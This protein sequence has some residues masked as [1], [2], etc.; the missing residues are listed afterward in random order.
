[1]AIGRHG[2]GQRRGAA[3]GA[4]LLALGAALVAALAWFALR[5]P[6]ADGSGPPAGREDPARR[7][8]QGAELEAPAAD[9][10]PLAELPAGAD[11]ARSAG[12][13][14]P[15]AGP[16]FD[17][18][19]LDAATGERVARFWV[20]RDAFAEVAA[21]VERFQADPETGLATLGRSAPPSP[22]SVRAPGYVQAQAMEPAPPGA[23]VEVRLTRESSIA[24]I[25][26]DGA[27]A[28][29]PAA[30]VWLEWYGPD[31]DALAGDGDPL[32]YE[33]ARFVRTDREGAY[34][35]NG[36]TPGVYATRA[37]VGGVTVRSDRAW[38]DEGE[39]AE[40]DHWLEQHA[41]V[42]ARV[43]AP[44]GTPAPKSLVLLTR[45][46]EDAGAQPA[47]RGYTGDDGRVTL[48]PLGAGRYRVVVVSDAGRS[49]VG[50]VTVPD[51]GSSE[52]DHEVRL[53]D[54]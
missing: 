28:P 36:L 33:G 11:A 12:R 40:I 51:R 47:A 50:F 29:V 39:W 35:F 46:E 54:S 22:L 45:A 6:G 21:G 9:P 38:V 27:S 24:G 44:D 7:A 53:T 31:K 19:A 23:R 43:L 30:R 4:A 25:V 14:E 37:E 16:T 32:E 17:V 20:K 15:V 5:A 52:I 42:L 3:R 26:R 1:M 41:A 18:V 10:A 8:G 48:G 13:V 34:R 2:R 49:P